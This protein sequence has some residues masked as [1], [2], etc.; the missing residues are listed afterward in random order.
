MTLRLRG[1][2]SQYVDITASPNAGDATLTLPT[3]TGTVRV[4]AAG[5][6]D[7]D[8]TVATGATI[9]GGSNLIRFDTGANPPVQMDSNGHVGIGTN[10][11]TS[12]A[13][14]VHGDI[15]ISRG[16]R[17]DGTG[18]IMFGS[19]SGDYLQLQDIGPGGNIFELVQD[20]SK[21]VVVRGTNGNVG[22][23]T[24]I[25]TKALHIAQ[26]SDCAIRIDANNSNAN[27]RAWEIVVGG[28]ASNNAEMV[29][30]TRQDD[31]TGGSECARFTR[32]GGIK[33]PSGGGINFHNYGS[34][35]N[36]VSNLLDDYE[37]G[38]WDP[39]INQGWSSVT[40]ANQFGWYTKV[41]HLVT[42][43]CSL[44]FS[45]TSAGTQIRVSLPFAPFNDSNNSR[46]GAFLT[47]FTA[48]VTTNANGLG[49]SFYI[50]QSYGAVAR[51]Y[52]I[53]DPGNTWLSNGNASND[54][55]EFTAVYKA[56]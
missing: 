2:S 55:I 39:T 16:G 13:L 1:S 6:V 46:S 34:G 3:T 7:G 8:Y 17:G 43:G 49:A 25:P 42:C 48:P 10:N 32:S 28:N 36:I 47:F 23:G 38:T 50:Y 29:L 18:K 56:A 52:L 5:G 30:R 14:D 19:D 45:G 24:E 54:W 37:E 33:L 51:G 44:Q 15:R 41:G 12:A 4:T 53:G 22:I 21:K 11:N 20:G 27:A 40:Y 9:T 26:N 35:S 31:G